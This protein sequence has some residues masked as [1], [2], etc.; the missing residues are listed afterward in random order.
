MPS[1]VNGVYSDTS[2]RK[3]FNDRAGYICSLRSGAARGWVVVYRA[4]DQG[5]DTAGG[6]YAT[7]C[8]THKTVVNSTN[9]PRARAAMK[10]PDFCEDCQ[11]HLA[12][13]ASRRAR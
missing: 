5:L 13:P 1:Y 4:A 12:P 2:T 11:P 9:L 3:P 8:E 7:V 6:P 10:H